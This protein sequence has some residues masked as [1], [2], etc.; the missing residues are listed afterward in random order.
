ME[1][2]DIIVLSTILSTLF[3]VFGIAVYREFSRMEKE[4]YQYNPN[5]KRYGRDALFYLAARL[6]A[7]E[8]VP[9]KDKEVIYKAVKRTIAD[10]ESDGIYFPQEAKEELR[11][12]REE[13]NCEYSGLPS[14]K[15]YEMN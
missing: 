11:R 7:D 1:N 12:Q 9:K 6:F 8:K 14:V 15:A 13:L 10:M 5:A 2:L 3:I 4:N